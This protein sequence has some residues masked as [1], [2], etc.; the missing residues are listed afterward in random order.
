MPMAPAGNLGNVS[1]IVSDAASGNPIAGAVIDARLGGNA[2]LTDPVVAT[3]TTDATGA[4]A[5]KYLTAGAYT[6]TFHAVGYQQQVFS[7]TV[8]AAMSSIAA[9][10]SLITGPDVTPPTLTLLGA[11][12]VTYVIGTTY[13]DA[14]ATAFDAVDGNISANIIPTVAVNFAVPGTNNTITYNVSDAAGNAATPVVRHVTVVDQTAPVITLTGGNVSVPQGGV[15]T[16]PG[17][18]ATDNVDGVITG[19]VTVTGGP[20]NTGA[21]IGTVFTLNYNVSDSSGNA[22]IQKSRT[23]TITQPPNQPPVPTAPAIATSVNTA[24]TSQ[25]APND[26]NAGD[27]HTYAVT[28]QAANGTATV[29]NTAPNKGLATYTPNAGFVGTDSFVVT[30]TDQGGLTGTVTIQ[31]TVNP[32]VG[33]WDVNRWDDGSRWQ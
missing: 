29:S 18:S 10:V 16:D 5:L 26:P 6:L 17:Y 24:G 20:V 23:V 9:P 30:V 3:A 14:G 25:V 15:F 33:Q 12:P 4:Y 32:V 27:T 13:R 22:A 1:G 31:V 8:V 2:P 7:V 21:A 28:T 11:N 19:R